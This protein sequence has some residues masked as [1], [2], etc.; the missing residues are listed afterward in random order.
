MA[1]LLDQAEVRNLLDEAE[2]N[3]RHDE[4]WNVG[5]I[6]NQVELSVQDLEDKYRLHM[7][8]SYLAQKE[9]HLSQC[10]EEAESAD[11]CKPGDRLA[12]Q[13]R[14]RAA[15]E[16]GKVAVLRLVFRTLAKKKDI[17]EAAVDDMARVLKYV[18]D[19]EVTKMFM[20]RFPD[21][22]YA[23]F[24]PNME[25]TADF[26]LEAL[27]KDESVGA[28]AELIETLLYKR[29]YQEAREIAATM[30]KSRHAIALKVDALFGSDPVANAK[31]YEE[32]TRAGIFSEFLK[33]DEG[34][35]V[36]GLARA[37][38]KVPHF[39]AGRKYVASKY[40]DSAIAGACL[41]LV[42][43]SDLDEMTL[44]RRI[45]GLIKERHFDKARSLAETLS[46]ISPQDGRRL[47]IV[48]QIRSGE[49]VRD[50]DI[51]GVDL[52]ENDR[53]QIIWRQ[54]E[55]DKDKSKLRR[56]LELT[57]APE[58]K[59]N[60][61][62]ELRGELSDQ[63]IEKQFAVLARA[64]RECPR[65]WRLFGDFEMSCG[66]E[67]QAQMVYQ[68]FTDLGG[69]DPVICD[70]VSKKYIEMGELAKALMVLKD[71]P[72]KDAVFRSALIAQRLGNNEFVSKRLE[73]YVRE[74]GDKEKIVASQVRAESCLRNN[75]PHMAGRIC[76][77]LA[78][79]G[80]D[81]LELEARVK[82]A[83]F[84]PFEFVD[85]A[86]QTP[87][88]LAERL[89]KWMRQ[90]EHYRISNRKEA[91][92][93]L[94]KTA[95]DYLAQNIE[96]MPTSAALLKMYGK[97]MIENYEMNKDQSSL[98]KAREYYKKLAEMETSAETFADVASVYQVS[99]NHQAAI[100]ILK[101]AVARFPRN[102]SLWINLGLEYAAIGQY[103]LSLHCMFV[104]QAIGGGDQRA[105][106][107]ESWCRTIA[108]LAGNEALLDELTKEER[109]E[110]GKRTNCAVNASNPLDIDNE[111]TN[112][113]WKALPEWEHFN[114]EWITD[115]LL[116]GDDQVIA[117]AYE[118]VRM[119]DQALVYATDETQRKRLLALTG[120]STEGFPAVQMS[121][122]SR[123]TELLQFLESSDD[124]L[125]HVGAALCHIRAHEYDQAEEHLQQAE[126]QFPD[127]K[128]INI[129]RQRFIP[130]TP[131][132]NAVTQSQ[133]Y[134]MQCLTKMSR[135]DAVAETLNLKKKKDD[136][137]Y[138]MEL[139]E[140]MRGEVENPEYL[141]DVAR[142]Y[143]KN[144]PGQK[145]LKLF[146]SA[147]LKV[148]EVADLRPHVQR[149]MI[150]RPAEIP[151]LRKLLEKLL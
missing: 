54:Y 111:P 26:K 99:G 55:D 73:N 48:I 53:A 9:K 109:E 117:N 138:R 52:S 38:L 50:D 146:I 144:N 132:N 101:R 133:T 119:Y 103:G 110:P 84:E 17:P 102:L 107:I 29:R 31:K 3:L 56:M 77:E 149:L 95:T 68:Q 72:E 60:A 69:T 14:F 118:S 33:M 92:V 40:P 88:I 113:E 100:Q 28:Q 61:L 150:M 82:N 27:R 46:E 49:L 12:W 147:H 105:D 137:M 58:L 41:E 122:E 140:L 64:N 148:G 30:D 67:A 63:E 134:F 145:S 47:A 66:K 11:L 90:I 78:D 15:R 71:R 19:E 59:A 136:Y 42:S 51:V 125:S 32:K 6:L 76:R 5:K 35:D 139:I 8:R 65:V 7:I 81:D 89:K 98:E 91:C 62:M 126:K 4:T 34:D 96:Q 129:L 128:A 120:A 104:A 2:A 10:I 36:F 114:R 112:R 18:D 106:I 108:R 123:L 20:E 43:S 85:S 93:A 83:L 37:V 116:T 70:L 131:V 57:E 23:R 127:N 94:L 39:V 13:V 21:V 124:G 80:A 44:V 87:I 151:R 143:L 115:A 25:C 121:R 142:A 130:G 86:K 74:C 24:L 75:S 97:L 1:G 135:A 141:L 45:E 79:M 16:L 22:R